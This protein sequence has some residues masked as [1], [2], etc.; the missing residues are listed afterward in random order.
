MVHRERERSVSLVVHLLKKSRSEIGDSWNSLI[1]FML[2]STGISAD[3]SKCYLRVGC[4]YLASCLRLCIWFKNPETMEGMTV[5]RRG[6]QA[7]LVVRMIQEKYISRA[8]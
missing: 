7:A 1:E 5:F 4:D 8:S 3:I 2:E 6:S